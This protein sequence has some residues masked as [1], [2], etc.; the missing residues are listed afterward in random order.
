VALSDVVVQVVQPSTGIKFTIK[1][2]TYGGGYSLVMR[3]GN[4]VRVEGIFS[5]ETHARRAANVF[6]EDVKIWKGLWA[7]STAPITIDEWEAH[8]K[9]TMVDSGSCSCTNPDCGA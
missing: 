6:W 1:R 2:M 5:T 9:M 8:K 4:D 7:P 3:A